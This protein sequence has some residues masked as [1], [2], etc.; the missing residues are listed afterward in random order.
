MPA[1]PAE[2]FDLLRTPALH[3]L[4]DGSGTVGE[5]TG[6]PDTKL[7]PGSRF[8]MSM[9][10]GIPYRVRNVVVEYE[11]DRLIAWRHFARHRWRYLLR[12]VEGGTLVTETFDYS[13]TPLPWLYG[14][15]L[16][17]RNAQAIERSLVLL[18]DHF[19]TP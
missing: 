7:G 17:E 19:A 13:H 11:P 2:V 5:A 18:R 14:L 3:P 1:T 15:G 9:R 10:W 4:I 12:P 8:G 16:A 6:D